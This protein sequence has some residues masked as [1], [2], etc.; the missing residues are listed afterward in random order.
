MKS[1]RPDIII[2]LLPSEL[3]ISEN[4]SRLEPLEYAHLKD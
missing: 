1:A 3:L 2:G 4:K